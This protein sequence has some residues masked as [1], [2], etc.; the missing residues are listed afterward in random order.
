MQTVFQK[1]QNEIINKFQKEIVLALALIL[2][3]AAVDHTVSNN[4]ETIVIDSNVDVY[5]SMAEEVQGSMQDVIANPS[6][7]NLEAMQDDLFYTYYP[8]AQ[9]TE[10]DKQEE[11]IAYLE[12]CNQVVISLHKTGQAD[13]TDMN[14]KYNSLIN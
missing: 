10:G 3:G 12:V 7:K 11:F 4:S 8:W 6:E 13:L 9:R 1:I 5:T 2:F 14:T